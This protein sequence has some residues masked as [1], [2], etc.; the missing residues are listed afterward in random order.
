[1]IC[2]GRGRMGRH[3]A[4]SLEAQARPASGA[5]RAAGNGIFPM[6]DNTRVKIEALQN[7]IY[8]NV[9]FSHIATDEKG[10]IQIFNAGAERM[11]GYKASEVVGKI[12]PADLSDP[13]ELIARAKA[14]SI[15]FNTPIAPVS[16]HWF[17]R[18]RAGSKTFMR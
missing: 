16:K 13:Q 11:L 7:A 12:T 8:R 14:L 9:N 4:D 6:P 10:I 5:T 15:E 18:P 3:E 2:P 1:M 17:S